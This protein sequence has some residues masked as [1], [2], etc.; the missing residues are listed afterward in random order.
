MLDDMTQAHRIRTDSQV[1]TKQA[2]YRLPTEPQEMSIGELLTYTG[3]PVDEKQLS[4]FTKTESD[5]PVWWAGELELLRRPA[6]SVIGARDASPNGIARAKKIASCLA[7]ANVIVTSGLAKGIDAAA[8]QAC[9]ASGG[10]TIAVIGTPLDKAYPAENGPL[11]EEIARRHLLISQFR[12]GQRTFAS[13]FP[14][15][16]RL[17]AA[18]TDASIIVEASDSS[19]TLHQAA[20][21][22]RLGRWLFIMQSVIE[23]RSLEWPHKFLGGP[24]VEILRSADQVISR[25]V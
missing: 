5:P 15:R 14:K 6:A 21:C 1:P 22:V 3:R 20:E 4:L 10:R 13:D 19:G 25:I 16:N 7:E 18:L 9:L 23:D 2:R 8:H 12:S 11:Q 24:K 17:M